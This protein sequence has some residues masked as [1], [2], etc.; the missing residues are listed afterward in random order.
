VQESLKCFDV[1]LEMLQTLNAV[2]NDELECQGHKLECSQ[3][4]C[5][6][7]QVSG[8]LFLKYRGYLDSMIEREMPDLSF[9][10]D[11]N[12]DPDDGDN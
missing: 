9:L 6:V 5:E 8:T 11:D 2:A 4:L 12:T 3:M 10:G 7:V 1:I